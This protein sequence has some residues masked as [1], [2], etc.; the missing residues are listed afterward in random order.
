MASP[1]DVLESKQV[2]PRGLIVPP[3]PRSDRMHIRV[4]H[5]LAPLSNHPG[6]I[7]AKALDE[8]PACIGIKDHSEL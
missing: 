5:R 3:K 2:P 6:M 1:V 7:C 8:H 4:D